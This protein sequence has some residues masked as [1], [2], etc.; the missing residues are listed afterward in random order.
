[1]RALIVLLFASNFTFYC[2]GVL[3]LF[4]PVPGS[5]LHLWR[6]TV[7]PYTT[8]AKGLIFF[9]AFNNRARSSW[10]SRP[11]QKFRLDSIYAASFVSVL[12]P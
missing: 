9:R 11:G 1:M 5:S 7:G 3:V 10:S 4:L 6:C 2:Y 12:V 8:P